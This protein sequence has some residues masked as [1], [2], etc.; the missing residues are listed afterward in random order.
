MWLVFSYN[1]YNNLLHSRKYLSLGKWSLQLKFG[2]DIGLCVAQAG[3]EIIRE[4]RKAL[5][6]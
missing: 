2:S 4:P 5:I 1:Q 3:L 6:F